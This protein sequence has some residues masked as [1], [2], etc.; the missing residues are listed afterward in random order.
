MYCSSPLFGP[1]SKISISCLG[2]DQILEIRL[3]FVLI[4]LWIT[5]LRSAQ[6]LLTLQSSL[7]AY[8]LPLQSCVHCQYSVPVCAVLA[9]LSSLHTFIQHDLSGRL[10]PSI[11]SWNLGH[12]RGGGQGLARPGQVGHSLVVFFVLNIWSCSSWWHSSKNVTDA[13]VKVELFPVGVKV[14]ET[15]VCMKV[16]I[17]FSSFSLN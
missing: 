12:P 13:F 8:Q 17:D 15:K 1:L 7:N 3:F 4:R 16:V 9:H 10:Q 5:A 11:S 2:L 6:C 14:A